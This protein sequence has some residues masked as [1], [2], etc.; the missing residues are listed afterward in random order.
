VAVITGEGTGENGLVIS[1]DEL[2]QLGRDFVSSN[3]NTLQERID[4]VKPEDMATI[5]YTSGT[6]GPPKGAVLTHG[7]FAWTLQSIGSVL[8]FQDGTER[9]LSYLP[10]SHIFERLTSDWGGI[11]NGVEVWFNEDIT[12][13][14]DNLEECRP[15]FFIGVPRV[16]EK[17]YMGLQ[18]VIET[19]P[20]K[21]LIKKAIAAATE[22]VELVQAGKP[23]PMGLRLKTALFDRLVISKLRH[24]LGMDNVRFAITGAAP[25]NDEILK[26]LFALGINVLEGY[27]QTED[28][29]PTS[30]NP[31][32]KPKIGTVGLPIPGLEVKIAE[33]GEI[34]VKG[35]NVFKGYFKNEEATKETMSD[36][37]YLMTGDIGEFDNE[38]YLKITDRKKDLIITAGGK[39]ISPQEIEGK[40]KFA[41]LVSQ[42][43]VIGDR[44]PFLTA[45]IT[46][47]PEIAPAWAKEQGI[48]FTDVT[49]LADNEKVQAAVEKIV[50]EVNSGLAKVETIKKWTVLPRD[51]TQEAEEITPT[52]KVKRKTINE[53]Y[54]DLIERMYS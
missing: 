41:P 21:D 33:D 54:G 34:L 39:N 8:P 23:V 28:N 6:T 18:K 4:G 30:V 32:H 27:G 26:F 19:H 44:R 12:K 49:E 14:K 25:I 2:R 43:V 36:D 35:P 53:K 15:T 1:F 29:A 52:L 11:H 47:D 3:P 45:L 22:K 16:Y 13:L 31:P 7:N 24:G 9:V 20:K 17:F 37:G 10:L 42:A 38:G 50:E 5:V 51:F 40:L 48:D 46:L